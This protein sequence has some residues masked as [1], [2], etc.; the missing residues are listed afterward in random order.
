MS[1]KRHVLE[2]ARDQLSP[3]DRE[4]AQRM[5]DHYLNVFKRRKRAPAL[6]LAAGIQHATD[7]RIDALLARSARQPSCSKGCAHCC[8]LHVDVMPQEARL[9]VEYAK[10]RGYVIDRERLAKQAPKDDSTWNELPAEDR[11]CV[12][13]GDDRTCQVY[14]H[15]PASCRKYLVVTPPAQCDAVAHPGGEVQV[16]FDL[17]AEIMLNAATSVLKMGSLASQVS[18]ILP[19]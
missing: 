8:Y 15:R 2:I 19:E 9:L 11:R 16:M 10:E 5:Q 6:N 7:Q 1:D 17:E 4:V 12:F 14:K 3:P 13:L 18:K